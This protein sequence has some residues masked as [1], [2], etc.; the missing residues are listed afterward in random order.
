MK[1]I[2]FFIFGVFL[3]SGAFAL[4]D[5]D[6][7]A[8]MLSAAKNGDMKYLEQ[9]VN[10][11]AD[12]NYID[13]TGMSIVCTALMNNDIRAAQILQMYGADASKCDRQIKKY[14]NKDHNK[15]TG[16]LFSGLSTAQEVALTTAGGIAVVGGL[17]FLTDKLKGSNNNIFGSNSNRP[18]NN[19]G[20]GSG[21]HGNNNTHQG[22]SKAL[23][24]Y[25]PSLPDAEA[26]RKDYA[27]NL[28][29]QLGTEISKKNF[30]ATTQL[31]SSNNVISQYNHL[32]AMRGYSPFARGYLGM[33]TLRNDKNEP[34]KI[35]GDLEGNNI[36]GGKPINIALITSNGLNIN[37]DSESIS[38]QSSLQDR[39]F[40]YT[41]KNV[42]GS[43]NNGSRD[44]VSN[45]YYNNK[46][47]NKTHQQGSQDVQNGIS[48][49][50]T[51]E[52]KEDI[53]NFDLS[54][55]G[56]A[57]HNKLIDNDD[58]YDPDNMLAKIVGG[59]T[60]GKTSGD[61]TG[62][63]PNGQ[64]TVYRTG[65]GYE[66]EEITND[67]GHYYQNINDEITIK[68]KLKDSE[69]QDADYKL[70]KMENGYYAVED[71]SGKDTGYLAYITKVEGKDN[72]YLYNK[73]ALNKFSTLKVYEVQTNNEIKLVKKTKQTDYKNYE[74]LLHAS[75]LSDKDDK[76]GFAPSVI[77][78]VALNPKLFDN[79][80]KTIT[81]LISYDKKDEY[82][83]KFKEYVNEYYSF[84]SDKKQGQK[85]LNFFENT[86]KFTIFSAGWQN[87]DSSG[88]SLEASFENSAPLVF[89]RLKNIFA[90]VV[91][92]S[93]P[94]VKKANNLKLSEY[95]PEN[96]I[97][98]SAY[99]IG[100]KKYKSRICGISGTGTKDTD[101]WC[102]SAIGN[103]DGQAVASMAGSVGILKSA[104]SYMDNKQLFALLA[105]TAD[106]P[107][108]KDC[109]KN[110]EGKDLEEKLKNYLDEMY[111]L[112]SDYQSGLDNNPNANYLELFKK[113]FGYGLINLE[114][115][116]TPGK[117]I[118]YYNGDR[119][120]SSK[121]GGNAYWGD[122]SKTR[123]AS[124]SVLRPRLSKISAQYYDMLESPDKSLSLPRIWK[125][126]FNLN[127][128]N[129]I[130]NISKNIF[131]SLQPFTRNSE[132]KI[133]N[134]SFALSSSGS[135]FGNFSDLNNFN[136]KYEK[137]NFNFSS[138]FKN[139]LTDNL[140][141]FEGRENQILSLVSNLVIA[142]TK[143]SL[144]N[145]SFKTSVFSGDVLDKN[146]ISK[147]ELSN[148][149]LESA[150]IGSATG[151]SFDV[152]FNKNNFNISSSIGKLN[153]KG[154]VLGTGTGGLL[155]LGSGG[156]IYL[157]NRVS[158]KLTNDINL[159][160][161]FIT[162]QTK[163]NN[164]NEQSFIKD[165]TDIYSN[166][167]S[168]NVDY[169]N[170]SFS[171]FQ[172]LTVYSGDMTYA[173]SDFNLVSKTKGGY[174]LS[175][176]YYLDKVSLSPNKELRFIGTYRKNLGTFTDSVFNFIYRLNPDGFTDKN[177]TILMMK[178][179]HRLGI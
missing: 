51:E 73:N 101:P 18:N 110:S 165:V 139:N 72:I 92:V 161:N 151:F 21:G 146:L 58:I 138:S 95:K 53:K 159:Q 163:T 123:F 14:K 61:I 91:S 157:D 24:S 153:E 12:I 152:S 74:A 135:H 158:Y 7:A 109:A 120:L 126:N 178:L 145:F 64:M 168:I 8:Q 136:I 112:P 149:L 84:E 11:G 131:E 128:E 54:G 103:Y 57:L 71:A 102:F 140:S 33:T 119:I 39:L 13:N 80:S 143:Y 155:D 47:T 36:S 37:P 97:E 78:N 45:K 22:D 35:T 176:K 66:L 164:R 81:S 9:L 90:T 148:S 116:T 52:K 38:Q 26:E 133:D 87:I 44:T 122:F 94:T 19:G 27:N 34:L 30:N 32:L 46:I 121:K 69:T 156:T 142:D 150:K 55:A 3:S 85:A 172:P 171:I 43:L 65:G 28:N 173:Y 1:F 60:S 125:H 115:A 106:G 104:F 29:S 75:N 167:Y 160:F 40:V 23:T 83:N 89:N 132:Q 70:K 17:F 88:K 56:T 10:N 50:K 144:K 6:T 98:L 79:S 111:K 2:G 169:K 67:T 107:F 31:D 4:S 113:V 99:K 130:N 134:F 118:Y 82:K 86:N 114:R 93:V 154:S 96:K 25:G 77:A 108:C 76:S 48:E 68:I 174:G 15:K 170:F 49:W 59:Y 179:S 62:F 124:S 20:N 166:A 129:N 117:T 16:G 127:K 141:N 100:T 41:S 137:D 5:F 177:E 175:S 147:S 42:N 105:L 162:S 63:M